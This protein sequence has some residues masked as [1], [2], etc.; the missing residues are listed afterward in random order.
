MNCRKAT[1][2]ISRRLDGRLGRR[3]RAALR[4]HLLMCRFC[5]RFA[6]QTAALHRMLHGGEGGAA[7]AA[8][9]AHGLEPAARAR[10]AARLQRVRAAHGPA[11]P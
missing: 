9:L 5:A 10:I 4:L 7:L 3:E 1:L 6:R 11:S 2:L 8:A